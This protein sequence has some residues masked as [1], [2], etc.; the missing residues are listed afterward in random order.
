[1][2]GDD[3]TAPFHGKTVEGVG[4]LDFKDGEIAG[5]I[6]IEARDGEKIMFEEFAVGVADAVEEH[7]FG[8]CACADG[9]E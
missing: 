6:D 3:A 2:P 1:M 9:E 4:A 7:F 5:G 8:Q